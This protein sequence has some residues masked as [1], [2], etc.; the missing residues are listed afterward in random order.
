MSYC[1]TW[2]LI[3]VMNTETP[4]DG[5]KLWLR[6]TDVVLISSP[7]GVPVTVSVA[8]SLKSSTMEEGISAM[9]EE[10]SPWM[11]VNLFQTTNFFL[12]GKENVFYETRINP[13]TGKLFQL[14]RKRLAQKDNKHQ[15]P[16][17]SS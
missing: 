16:I 11:A 4:L 2:L 13:Q 15:L 8:V 3:S 9:K 10:I 14:R 5:M 1:S 17:P 12:L 6:A 7:Q